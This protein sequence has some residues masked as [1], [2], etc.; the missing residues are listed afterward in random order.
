ML[1]LLLI[2][3]FLPQ[4]LKNCTSYRFLLKK[5]FTVGVATPISKDKKGGLTFNSG[6]QFNYDLPYN[7]T[8]FEPMLLSQGRRRRPTR[9]LH[10][11]NLENIYRGL[12][13]LLH[14]HGW[15]DGKQCLL[16]AICELAE[17]P[18]SGSSH[19]QDDVVEEIVHLLLTPS[20]E[21][22]MVDAKWLDQYREAEMLGRDGAD[23]EILFRGCLHS[24]LEHFTI[25]R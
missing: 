18:L 21:E 15:G 11:L 14:E 13:Q 20:E 9:Q 6:F 22:N 7:L 24:P 23:C 12:E 8:Q 10:Q 5:L 3:P 4:L 16:R 17:T 25:T 2:V 1:L 19:E